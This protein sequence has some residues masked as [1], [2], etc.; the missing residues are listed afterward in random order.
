MG[1][2]RKYKLF[3]N[4]RWE[5]A[6]SGKR[7]PSVNPATGEVWAEVPEGDAEDIDRAVAAARKAFEE[8]P[9]RTMAPIERGKL[10]RRLGDLIAENADS[11]AHLETQDNGKAI[12]ETRGV[13][14]PAIPNWYYYFAGMADKIEG[15]TIPLGPGFFNYTVREPVGVV[16]AITPWNSPLLMYAFKLAPAL[17]AG[18]TVVLKPAEQTSV[19]ALEL[20]RLIEEAGFPPG[21]VNIVPGYGEMAG[22]ALVKHPGV[23]KIAFTGETVTGQYISQEATV[24]LKRVTCELGGKSPNIVFED[25]DIENA[26]RGAIAGVFVAAGQ[27]CVAGSRLFLHEKIYN[28]FLERLLEK[29]RVIRVGDPLDPKTHIGSLVSREQWERVRGYVEIGKKEGA[30]ILYGGQPPE[31]PALAR[32]SFFLPTVFTDVHNRMR[33]A[34]EE[35]FGPVVCVLP[36]REEEEVI[37]AANDVKYGLAGGVWTQDIKRAHR[38]VDRIKAGTVWINNYRRVHFAS[39]FGGYK[40]SGYG[41]ENGFEVLREYTQVKNV[42]VDLSPELPDPYPA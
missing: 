35:I 34:Q 6:A 27:T 21:V 15:E 22:A 29:T 5:E 26:V 20:A 3:I 39:P 11:L 28:L 24:N 17:A 10:I 33:I 23:D 7:L 42:W 1:E 2:I 37:A 8:G 9:W 40:L 30:R 36:F 41:R 12:R 16:G 38:I 13:E 25:A 31:D 19:T 18:N 32:G 14:L 4:N